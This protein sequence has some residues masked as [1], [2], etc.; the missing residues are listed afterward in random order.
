MILGA[1]QAWAIGS[2]RLRPWVWVVAT[3]AGMAAGV[4]AGAAWVG[5]QTDLSSL[6]VQGAVGGAILGVAQAAVLY[7]RLG[8]VVIGWPF[9]LSGTFAVGWV[10]TTAAGI[11]VEQQF[12]I[13]GSSGALVAALLTVVLPLALSDHRAAQTRVTS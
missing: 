4:A 12:T 10:V 13:F 7:R 11:D 9:Y 6:A 1:V 2:A 8:A 5:Y 3:G